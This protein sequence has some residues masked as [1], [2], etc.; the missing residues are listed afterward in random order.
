MIRTDGGD[1]AV[2]SH[3]PNPMSVFQPEDGR[4]LEVNDA[5]VRLYGWSRDEARSMRVSDVSAEPTETQRAV[6]AATNTGGAVIPLR[7]H[8]KKDGTVFPVE[9]TSGTLRVGERQLMYAVMADVTERRRADDALHRSEARFRALVEG[10]PDGILVHRRSAVVYMN[11]AL[12]A[13]LG[14]RAEDPVVGMS[15]LD[16]VDPDQRELVRDR[17]RH[18]QVDGKPTPLIEFQ[19]KRADGTTVPTEVSAIPVDYD[20]EPAVLAIFRDVSGRKKLEAQLVLA[21]RLSSLGRLAAS[22]GH[23]INNPLAYMLG[24]VQVLQREIDGNDEM[25]TPLRSH[26]LERL[27]VLEQGTTRVRDIVHDL[28]ALSVSE[29][30]EVGPVDLHGVLDTC[31]NMAEHEIR[32]RAKLVRSYGPPAF[33]DANE[34]RLGQVF[35]NLLI[36]AAQALPDSSPD[37]HEVR[38]T[39]SHTDRAAVVIEVADTGEGIPTALRDRIFE[40]FFTTKESIGTGL[41]LSISHS[42]V[43]SYGGTIQALPNEPRGAIIRVT[44]PLRK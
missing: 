34:A 31:A 5:W 6:S 4:I 21:D 44:L 42:I 22:V 10:M 11:P 33:V 30:R 43:T 32:Y 18:V 41:G 35:L 16:F 2:F 3:G 15:P 19:V 13:L 9:L 8:R 39:T 14:Y 37:A 28:K 20:G 38:I 25:A 26:L 36:N 27:A 17:I 40:P 29:R 12:R 1:V 7:W 23:E 24:S